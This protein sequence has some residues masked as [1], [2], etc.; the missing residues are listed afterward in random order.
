MNLRNEILQ[1]LQLPGTATDAEIAE[2]AAAAEAAAAGKTDEEKAAEL[3]AKADA[4][5]AAAEAEAADD[6]ETVHMRPSQK[7]AWTAMKAE[8]EAARQEAA[9]A[10]AEAEAARKE[11]AAAKEAAS[12]VA[13]PESVQKETEALRQ[14]VRELDAERDPE[15]VKKYDTPIKRNED[16]VVAILVKHKF[17][18]ALDEKGN[19]VD[20]PE[21]VPALL[22]AGVTF[23][24]LQKQIAA[25]EKAGA[26]DDAETLREFLR[27]NIRLR[28][29]R[30]LEVQ[31]IKADIDGRNKA[32]T[33]QGTT[34]LKQTIEA[35]TAEGN[36]VL[37]EE[38]G[39]VAKRHSFLIKP[40]IL[41]TDTPAQ[42]AAK[43]ALLAE[44]EKV[45]AEIGKTAQSIATFG[46]TGRDYV[47]AEGRKNALAIQS[48]VLS[49]R[50][51]PRL[52][53]DLAKAQATIKAQEAEIAKYKGAGAI[54][55]AHGAA[56][57]TGGKKG[58]S[59]PAG[60][61][62]EEGLKAFA[63]SQGVPVNT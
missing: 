33:E 6:A 14:Q 8:R 1:R 30:G 18:K 29:D 42:Q 7:K 4:E 56:A 58:D 9:A 61:S 44:F 50:V 13:V 34:Q 53:A 37:A 45:D 43:K 63:A 17:D 41:P 47:V 5:K 22:K 46:K 48:I 52:E 16:A 62:L 28:R 32:R 60:A 55:R 54:S 57:Q 2:E 21:N 38:L 20:A 40:E 39:T 25:L 10:K 12:K 15:I 51:L 27:E 24:N 49:Q 35:I 3:F 23:G 11:A 59:V 36:R 19:L 31:T 26:V